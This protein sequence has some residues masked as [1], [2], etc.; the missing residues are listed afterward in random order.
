MR[1]F[2]AAV[3]VTALAGNAGAAPSSGSMPDQID[4]QDLINALEQL[5]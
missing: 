5:R 3:A 1:K 2:L 4:A